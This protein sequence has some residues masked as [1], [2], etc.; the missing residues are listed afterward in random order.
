MISYLFEFTTLY[1]SV[2]FIYH[3]IKT[4]ISFISCLVNF[5][6]NPLIQKKNLY[7]MHNNIVLKY[8]KR[9]NSNPRIPF[10]TQ[11]SLFVNENPVL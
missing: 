6:Q 5:Y 4:T 3:N 9:V 10:V 7:I 1:I 8:D 11:D 2:N